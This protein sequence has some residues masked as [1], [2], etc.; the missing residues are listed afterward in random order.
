M[1]NAHSA[2]ILTDQGQFCFQLLYFCKSPMD[3]YCFRYILRIIKKRLLL[4][5]IIKRLILFLLLLCSLYVQ[6]YKC[7]C[8]KMYTPKWVEFIFDFRNSP[9][10]WVQYNNNLM[11]TVTFVL[12]YVITSKLLVCFTVDKLG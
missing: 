6:F 8:V 11:S 4:S 9:T 12:L 3:I 5:C 7:I 1:R 2:L 10:P